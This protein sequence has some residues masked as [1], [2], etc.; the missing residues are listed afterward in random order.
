VTPAEKELLRAALDG[1]RM[2]FDCHGHV[3]PAFLLLGRSGDLVA[4]HV[5]PRLLDM[6]D[7]L[8]SAMRR[9]ASEYGATATAFVSECWAREDEPAIREHLAEGGD[10]SECPGRRE[11]VQVTLDLDTGSRLFMAEISRPKEGGATLGQW[12][13]GEEAAGGRF[14]RMVARVVH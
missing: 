1:A 13:E 11:C 9:I 12:S 10:L 14:A 7:E 5:D 3:A 6:K 4:A 2:N 8:A